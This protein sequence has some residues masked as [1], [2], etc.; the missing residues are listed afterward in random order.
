VAVYNSSHFGAAAYYALLAA[1]QGLIGLSFTHADALTLSY[2]GTR[3]YFGTNPIC[4]AAPCD[5]EEPFC[6]DMAPT[7]I[8]WNRVMQ[9][10]E[11]N[12]EIPL[13]LVADAQGLPTTDPHLATSLIP[14]GL[15]KGYGIA[16]MVE[17]LCSLLTGMPFGRHISKMFAPPIDQKRYLGQFFIAMQIEGFVAATE[18]KQ[19][20]AEMMAEVRA[21]PIA[22]PA[23]PVLV[24]GDPEKQKAKGRA[25]TG[26]PLT[27]T[28]WQEFQTLAKVIDFALEARRG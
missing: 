7:Q 9:H 19:R 28:Q 14:I 8:T 17:I 18:F 23:Q 11:Q 16:M 2:N 12:K 27:D 15:Y 4:L 26:I 3:P 13:G 21:E 24:P 20:L 22:D 25:Q 1:Q 10:R 5:G 6:F